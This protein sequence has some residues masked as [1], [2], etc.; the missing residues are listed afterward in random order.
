MEPIQAALTAFT[1]PAAFAVVAS[2]VAIVTGYF[3][4]LIK[5]RAPVEQPAPEPVADKDMDQDKDIRHLHT[6]ISEIKDR[7]ATIETDSKI[8]HTEIGNLQ[9]QLNGHEARVDKE[10]DRLNEKVDKLTDILMKVLT[11]DKL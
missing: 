3:G 2:V 11:D 5:T 1:W 7:T 6:R 4:Y 10:F 8:N 9:N